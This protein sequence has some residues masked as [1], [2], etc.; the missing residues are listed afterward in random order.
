MKEYQVQRV[1]FKGI[2][3]KK[4]HLLI[5]SLSELG[6]E[7]NSDDEDYLYLMINRDKEI[8]HSDIVSIVK[9]SDR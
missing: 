5:K 6:M 7:N 4:N 1:V 9:V 2:N 8:E 3:T